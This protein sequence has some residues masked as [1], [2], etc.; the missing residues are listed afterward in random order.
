MIRVLI[1]DDS[2]IARRVL[3]QILGTA[4]DISVV[5]EA[6]DAFTA[7]DRIVELSPDVMLLDIEMPK[8]DGLTFLRRLMHYQPMPVV[9]C[10]SLTTKGGE[11]AFDAY[12]AGAT[13]VI[14]KPNGNY[15]RAQI[16][17]DLVA[18][19]RSAAASRQAAAT[20]RERKDLA[21]PAVELRSR[22]DIALVAI[23]ASTGGTIAV[24][25]IVRALP[26]NMPAVLIVQ[27]MPAYITAPFAA[28]LRSLARIDVV[29]A[30]DG[31][32]VRD[33][34][35][36]VA[37]GG[38]HMTLERAGGELRVRVREGPRVNGHCPS[39]D[40]LF[41]SVA[42]LM[43]SRVAGVLLTGMGRDG[44]D[45][46]SAMHAE[47]AHT[48]AQD[49]ASSVVFGMPRAAIELGAATEVAALDDIAGRLVTAL[50]SSGQLPSSRR[51]QRR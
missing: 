36:L 27:H 25:T 51:L 42:T 10:S 5:G 7:R 14:G 29:E 35:A 17:I 40:V 3:A 47:G 9:V 13:D 43:G 2:V 30:T 6:G 22:N 16:E 32:V 15:T 31:Q 39:V 23:G 21:P 4:P 45:G 19:V 26:S 38:K 33:G 24:E 12:E 28:R 50:Q 37:A 18:A 41:H 8:M 1:V 11:V 44:A 34:Q 49:E 20:R 48:I 46:M